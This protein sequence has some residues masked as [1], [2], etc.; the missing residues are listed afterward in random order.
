MSAHKLFSGISPEDIRRIVRIE[1]SDPH[2]VLGAH[3]ATVNG[4]QGVIIRAFHPDAL[5]AECLL[6][7]QRIPME[8]PGPRGLFC[9]FVP[10]ANPPLVYRISF[11]FRDQDRW[12][13]E[14]PYRFLPT[15]GDLDLH[16]VGEGR[17]YQL[18]E[19]LGA[20]PQEIDGVRGVAFA[21][22][23]PAAKRVSLVG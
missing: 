12:V 15:L 23:A 20:H 16:F 8:M 4:Q 6:G 5:K 2:S 7:D 3:P 18:Y 9:C 13:T 17:H 1:H 11:E 22:W 14:G 19:K 10:G 21:V